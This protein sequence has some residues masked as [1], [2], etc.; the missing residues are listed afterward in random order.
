[1]PPAVAEIEPAV[2]NAPTQ[3]T[4]PSADQATK[5]PNGI[6][7]LPATIGTTAWITATNRAAASAGPPRARRYSSAPSK[8]AAP[9]RW[10]SREWRSRGPSARPAAYPRI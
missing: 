8:R 1:M 10:P 6:R 2:A 3:T 7:T 9:I 5:R 4:V